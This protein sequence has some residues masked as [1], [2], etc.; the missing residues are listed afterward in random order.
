MEFELAHAIGL[1]T[2]AV[3][4]A[5]VWIKALSN[6]PPSTNGYVKKGEF[7]ECVKRLEV[8]MSGLGT[9]ISEVKSDVREIRN[10]L[11]E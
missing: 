6:R 1:G 2:V 5:A 7:Q 9:S 11:M 3:S 10:R 8:Q 4:A